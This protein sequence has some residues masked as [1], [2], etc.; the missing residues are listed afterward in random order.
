MSPS[1]FELIQINTTVPKLKDRFAQVIRQL[2][3]SKPI[4]VDIL[5]MLSYVHSC[6]T[7]VSFDMLMA[8]LRNTTSDYKEIYQL[9]QELGQMVADYGGTAIEIND[10]QDYFIPRSTLI[11][12][13]RSEERRVGKECRSRWS[14]YH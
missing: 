10:N 8:F 5:V 2:E 1:L 7:P 6:R 4:L 14:P 12:E 13:A 9:L 3:S 11:A